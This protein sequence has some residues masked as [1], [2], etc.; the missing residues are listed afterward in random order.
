MPWN[1]RLIA[2]ETKLRESA[3]DFEE[4]DLEDAFENT[5]SMYRDWMAKDIEYLPLTRPGV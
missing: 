4:E 2:H 1:V 5:W 3:A